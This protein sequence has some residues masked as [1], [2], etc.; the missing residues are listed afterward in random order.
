MK[1]KKL[2]SFFKV[3]L[4]TS[5]AFTFFASNVTKASAEE[6]VADKTYTVPI[7][8]L[9]CGAPLPPVKKAFAKAFGNEIELIEKSDG[10]KVAKIKPEHMI[11]DLMGKYHCNILTVEGAK[12]LQK[13]NRKVSPTFGKPN[14][15]VD[16]EVPSE[17]EVV[18]PTPNDKGGY[19]FTVTVDFM[20][21]FIGGGVDKP[22]PTEVTMFLDEENKTEMLANYSKVDEAIAK[23]PADLS[24][25]T[26]ES[27]DR[28]N[29]AKEG[30]V[31]DLG[32]AQQAEVD[33]MAKAI[34]DAIA[35]LEEIKEESSVQF[36][37]NTIY[38]VEVALYN[39]DKDQLS[40][41][42]GSLKKTAKIFVKDGNAEMHI[43]TKPMT[44]GTITASLQEIKVFDL[45]GKSFKNGEVVAKSSDGNP[46]E[47]KFMLPHTEEFIKTEVNPHVA[48]MGNAFIPARIKVNYDTLKKVGVIG[49]EEVNT[50]T[51][52]P[53]NP[54][55]P[56]ISDQP[57][58]NT[59][60]ESDLASNTSEKDPVQM[61]QT[62]VPQTGIA[63]NALMYFALIVVS[64]GAIVMTYKRTRKA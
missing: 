18:L 16:I 7:K 38:E 1:E 22:H 17:V 47:F 63:T 49:D 44:M 21:S 14:D 19:K 59:S 33:Q 28:L 25:Y 13:E 43:Y 10:T 27:V 46:I 41:A 36:E 35:K 62:Q 39:A 56:E 8:N 12:V 4:A 32:I 40:M 50:P 52:D 37:D 9:E 34:E 11:V 64:A 26:K 42:A 29:V 6:K 57:H 24:K 20:N 53:E 45:D 54:T 15:I 23:I 51:V 58:E 55:N 2:K 48:I 61:S 30:V 3:V 31:R 60:T 5:M